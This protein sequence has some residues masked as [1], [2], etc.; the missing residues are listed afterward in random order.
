MNQRRK[1]LNDFRNDI[2][3]ILVENAGDIDN[4]LAEIRTLVK[5]FTARPP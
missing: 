2:Q 1:L 3:S 4:Q 5:K